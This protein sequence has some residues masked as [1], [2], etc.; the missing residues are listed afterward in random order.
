MIVI[1]QFGKSLLSAWNVIQHEEAWKQEGH[2]GKETG[3]LMWETC[4]IN[5]V[6][7]SEN[8]DRLS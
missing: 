3:I 2:E 1:A 5:E 7:C 8:L 6:R 4:L